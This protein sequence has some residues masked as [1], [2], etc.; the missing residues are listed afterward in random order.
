[1]GRFI[2]VNGSFSI[3]IAKDAQEDLCKIL[4]H[5][6]CHVLQVLSGVFPDGYHPAH[7]DPLELEAIDFAETEAAT[8]HNNGSIS[9]SSSS[10]MIL[11]EDD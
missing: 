6:F 5:E 10:I 1:M 11:D 8:I 9:S 4:A 7:D 2:E 3:S